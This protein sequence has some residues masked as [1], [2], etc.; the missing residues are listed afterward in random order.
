MTRD[1]KNL[2]KIEALQIELQSNPKSLSFTQLADLYLAENMIEE[3]EVL[4][5][6]SLK[7]YPHSVSGHLLYA[8][9]MQ[10]QNEFHKA[11][12]HLNF[13]IQKAPTNWNSYLLRAQVYLKLNQPKKALAD[14]KNL[15]LHNPTHPVARRS[16]AKLEMLTADDYDDEL[17]EVKSLSD[18]QMAPKPLSIQSDSVPLTTVPIKLER[19]LSLVDAFIV[20][21]EYEKGLKLL[22]EC[23]SEFGDHPEISDR[24]LKLTQFESAE[25]IR[26]KNEA[27]RSI[28]RSSLITEKKLKTL[29]LLL[30][31]IK[32]NRI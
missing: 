9:T 3:A 6:R 1:E 20:R 7:Y 11:L 27:I 8:R 25:K 21:R 23:Q 2:Q 32:E 16:V 24:L 17:F 13:A 29:E 31:R 10:I 26:P 30:R 15:L 5:A 22:R 12:E 28:S 14:Y 4:L 19:V 18:F